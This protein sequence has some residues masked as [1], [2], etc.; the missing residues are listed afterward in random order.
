MDET[1]L[2]ASQNLK[3]KVAQAGPTPAQAE[4]STSGEKSIEASESPSFS[5]LLGVGSVALLWIVFLFTAGANCTGA[6]S[7][8]NI[9]CALNSMIWP[10]LGQ[11]GQRRVL[12]GILFMA[13]AIP[14]WAI[15]M[16]WVIH[17]WAAVNAARWKPEVK[18]A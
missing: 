16:G 6:G 9:F 14:L 15:Y 8:G 5:Q 18:P 1:I 7:L 4:V 13:A 10:G 3:N 11:I 12:K 2:S 17:L